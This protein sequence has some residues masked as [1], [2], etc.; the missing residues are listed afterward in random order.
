MTRRKPAPPEVDPEVVDAALRQLWA[1]AE[2]RPIPQPL[3]DL[4]E[5]LEDMAD[6]PSPQEERRFDT[7]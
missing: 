4:M 5:R 1:Q 3:F 6:P 7:D 2:A